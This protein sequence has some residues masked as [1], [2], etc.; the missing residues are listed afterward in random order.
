MG[1]GSFGGLGCKGPEMWE[2]RGSDLKPILN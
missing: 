2:S 1:L